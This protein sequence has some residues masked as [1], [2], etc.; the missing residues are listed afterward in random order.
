MELLPVFLF[1]LCGLFFGSFLLVL[2]DR[3]PRNEDVFFSRSYCESCKKHLAWY[4]LIPI[5][6]F[7]LQRGRCGNC[8]VALSWWY[9]IAEMGTALNFA[10]IPI[11]FP[12]QDLLFY[13]FLI[14]ILSV[15]IVIFIAD[16]KYGIIPFPMVVIGI[17]TSLGYYS[18]SQPDK[19]VHYLITGFV[20]AL[21]FFLIFALTK[22]KGMGFGDVVFAFLMG[23][24]LGFPSIVI[25]IY[26]AF[27]TG[28]IVSLILILLKR[29]KYRGDTIAFGPFLIF[30]TVMVFIFEDNF[31]FLFQQIF[32]K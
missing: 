19:L 2:A 13:I 26:M 14:V 31:L 22:G 20:A 10:L 4:E 24:L 16:W 17:V 1:F 27:L 9:P 6:S 8:K 7:L 25:G 21:V 23:L 18:L 11:L 5:V 30:A 32:F 29:K 12:R 15:F 3:L 28:A